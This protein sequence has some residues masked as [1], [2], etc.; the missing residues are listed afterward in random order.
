MLNIFNN[1]I[2]LLGD[3]ALF[4]IGWVAYCMADALWAFPLP[5]EAETILWFWAVPA[6]LGFII[7][8]LGQLLA[9]MLAARGIG[10]PGPNGSVVPVT[11]PG[12]TNIFVLVIWDIVMLVPLPIKIAMILIGTG[13][14]AWRFRRRRRP[15]TP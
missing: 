11:I 5:I 3:T 9:Q 14:A 6:T 10:I 1:F 2:N 8:H 15:P 13:I 7:E 12:G 4:V